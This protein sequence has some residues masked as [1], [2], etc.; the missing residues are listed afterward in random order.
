MIVHALS[1]ASKHDD[2][3]TL[4]FMVPF[5]DSTNPVA[6]AVRAATEASTLAN[7]L[8]DTLPT[9]VWQQLVRYVL[10]LAAGQ[11]GQPLPDQRLPN[12]VLTDVTEIPPPEGA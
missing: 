5:R 4:T 1:K 11:F 6:T 8:Y 9:S 12:P 3:L 10:T 2:D 7:A